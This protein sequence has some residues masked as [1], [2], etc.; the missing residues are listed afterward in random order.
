MG[1]VRRRSRAAVRENTTAASTK[2]TPTTTVT[3]TAAAVVRAADGTQVGVQ[4]GKVVDSEEKKE[5]ERYGVRVAELCELYTVADIRCESFYG[6]PRDANYFA[7]RRREIFVAIRDRI[8]QG[9]R[10]L[11]VVDGKSGEQGGSVVVASC[12]VAFYAA[13]GGVRMELGKDRGRE[14]SI[15][16]SSM[17]VREGWRGR[18][19]AQRL[20]GY[21]DRMVRE[22]GVGQAFLHVE[23]DNRAAVHVYCKCGFQVVEGGTP[24]WLGVLAKKEH[25]LM[26]KSYE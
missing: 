20:L 10:C 2:T 19:L 24:K 11:V 18:G 13:I 22:F 4:V 14:G 8:A 6:A 17:A 7:V 23:W 16:V 5:R 3:T 15:Y 25:T 9:N 1:S 26:R 12:D 21:V